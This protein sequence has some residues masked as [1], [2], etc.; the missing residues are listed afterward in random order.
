M[1]RVWEFYYCNF[2]FKE[3]NHVKALIHANLLALNWWPSFKPTFYH[4][5]EMSSI[6]DK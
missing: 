6:V 2:I 5:R 3:N 1:T 4:A